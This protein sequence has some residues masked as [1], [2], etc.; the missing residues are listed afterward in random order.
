MQ[1]SREG[2][3]GSDGPPLSP[4]VAELCL[5]LCLCVGGGEGGQAGRTTAPLGGLLLC[6]G[7]QWGEGPSRGDSSLLLLLF[8]FHVGKRCMWI[9]FYLHQKC[10]AFPFPAKSRVKAQRNNVVIEKKEST[11]KGG[12]LLFSIFFLIQ[13]NSLV[14]QHVPLS[15]LFFGFSFYRPSLQVESLSIMSASQRPRG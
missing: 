9:A 11:I 1:A 6:G 13:T 10:S 3:A 15:P 7:S 12:F 2:L 14:L 4:G 5:L 8:L